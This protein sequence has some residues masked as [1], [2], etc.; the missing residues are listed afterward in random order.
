M[1]K[2]ISKTEKTGERT[3]RGPIDKV[4]AEFILANLDTSSTEDRL[5][6]G[7]H[8]RGLMRGRMTIGET[9]LRDCL[10]LRDHESPDWFR[11]VPILE[12]QLEDLDK[13]PYKLSVL[14]SVFPELDWDELRSRA[15][16]LHASTHA[17]VPDHVCRGQGRLEMCQSC[18]GFPRPDPPPAD[19]GYA[20]H[21]EHLDGCPEGGDS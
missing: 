21:V 12:G 5:A 7:R 15:E 6:A 9:I 20:T 1:T 17:V 2:Q 10:H 13:M 16:T 3:R 4:S 14:S 8:M 19:Q 11:A 18:G